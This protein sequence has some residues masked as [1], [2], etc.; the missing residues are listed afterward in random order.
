[1][2]RV[3]LLALFLTLIFVKAY[4]QTTQTVLING[5]PTEALFVSCV[6]KDYTISKGDLDSGPVMSF[7]TTVTQGELIF[8]QPNPT[9]NQCLT[10]GGEF[11]LQYTCPVRG[12]LVMEHCYVMRYE[13]IKY[14]GSP[15]VR[16]AYRARP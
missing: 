12:K 14:N 5:S 1:M 2:R 9:L 16:Y 15:A 6:S 4:P 10:V 7:N 11:A 13:A 8:A 3:L